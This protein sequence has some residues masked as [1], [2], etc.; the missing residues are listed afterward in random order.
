M[1][2]VTLLQSKATFTIPAFQAMTKCSLFHENPRL[3]VSACGVQCPVF[4]SVFRKFLSPLEENVINMTDTN[5]TQ[6]HRFSEAF[7]FSEIAAKF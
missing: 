5:F 3:T 4:F 2:S 7:G 6:L 1:A